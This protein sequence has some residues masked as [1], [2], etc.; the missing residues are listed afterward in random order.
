MQRRV[1]AGRAPP[2]T[3]QDVFGTAGETRLL[4]VYSQN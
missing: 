3:G 4:Q 1:S 2:V